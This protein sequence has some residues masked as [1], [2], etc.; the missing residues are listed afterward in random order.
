MAVGW[1]RWRRKTS[2]PAPFRNG[3]WYYCYKNDGLQNQSVL[4][5][6]K[7]LDASPE[8]VIDPNSL[9]PDGTT[10]LQLFNLSK[11]GRYAVVGLSKGGSDWQTFYVRDMTTGKNLAD[12]L[13]WVKV[14][15]AAWADNG[16]YYSRYPAPENNA[17]DLS[18]KNENHQ[19]YYHKVGTAQSEDML[20]F[21]DK[22][23]PQ[24]FHT[25][26]TSED[27]RYLYLYISDRGKGFDGNAISYMDLK[28][29]DKKFKP[30]IAKISNDD[31][32][33]VENTATTFILKTTANAPNAKLIALDIKNP[34]LA[35]AVDLVKEKPEPLQ[36]VNSVG[37]KLFLNYL[38]DVSVRT[39]VHEF[40]GRYIKEVKFPGLGTAGGFGGNHDDTFT[41]YSFTSF[42]Y[43]P[44][45]YK[46][47][48]ASGNSDLFR[49]P[50]VSFDPNMYE[51]KQVFFPS[52][53]G[54]V[55]I[56]MFIVHKKN[57]KLD[58]NNVTLLYGYG[59]FNIS[60]LPSSA[61]RFLA[62]FLAPSYIMVSGLSVNSI[63]SK[64][65]SGTSS[66]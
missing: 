11:D 58:G 44:T 42:N 10:R 63:K 52:K 9:S 5:R 38:K 1:Y 14:S 49:A 12:E 46:Y 59:G 35:K 43:P 60:M 16:F 8:V 19:V 30:L 29:D 3:E 61:I 33:V 17:S 41:F 39:Y 4:Y 28:A 40:N 54:N 56:P 66:T 24:R 13:S 65:I 21:E 26:Q 62:R 32:N 7:G 57:T 20:V 47:D 23:N 31:Y 15:G 64:A 34:D 50:E 36:Q 45:I 6:Q 25:T 51:T 37:G 55:K 53:D 18:A 27:E 22:A 48:I 2:P